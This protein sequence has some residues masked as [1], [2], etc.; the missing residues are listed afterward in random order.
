MRVLPSLL[1]LLLLIFT[2]SYAFGDDAASDV[3]CDID[4][5][6]VSNR[7]AMDKMTAGIFKETMGT[8]IENAPNV[9]D[10]SCLP[11]LDTLDTLIRLRI[12]SIGG[13]MGGLMT[14]IRD[15]ACDVANGFIENAVNKASVSY[16][17]PLG[18]SSVG[19]GGTTGGNGGVAV[20]DYDLTDQIEK[21]V[22]DAGK[23]VIKGP[24]NEVLNEIPKAPVDR[25]PRI[26][27]SISG[28]L[29]EAVRGL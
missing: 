29:S 5:M 9:K 3:N 25:N 14:K 15:M 12:P 17:D 10:A 19:I 26:D 11:A 28:E 1:V 20:D 4:Q 8:A 22:I 6:M 16:T 2:S 24:T 18:I 7:Q 13:M 23:G 27:R 21:G